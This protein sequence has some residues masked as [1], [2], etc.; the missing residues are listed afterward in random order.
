MQSKPFRGKAAVLLA[1]AGEGER[2]RLLLT[3]RSEQLALHRGEVAFPGGKWE[4]GDENLLATALRE[5]EEEVSLNPRDVTVIGDLPTSYTRGGIAVSSY[6]A[7]VPEQLQLEANPGELD[8]LFW[9]PLNFFS[10]DRR[11]RTDIFQY[12]EKEEWAPVYFYEDYKIWGFTARLIV[13]LVNR[14]CGIEVGRA[15]TAPERAYL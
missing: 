12:G 2:Q 9:V 4:P 10:E 8:A 15:N 11:K 7:Q 5:S 13:E 3:K 1:I 6:V 14:Y